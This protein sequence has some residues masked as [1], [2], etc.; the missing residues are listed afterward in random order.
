[1]VIYGGY[2]GFLANRHTLTTPYHNQKRP[3]R[4]VSGFNIRND[5][6]ASFAASLKFPAYPING[7]GRFKG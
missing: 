5:L 3:R 6:A 2:V 4:L 7:F 1:M